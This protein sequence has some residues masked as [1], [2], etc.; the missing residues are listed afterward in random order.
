MRV[1]DTPFARFHA[2]AGPRHHPEILSGLELI[3]YILDGKR[4]KR[5]HPSPGF[6]VYKV[7]AQ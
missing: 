2:L 4:D 7:V 6:S 3:L 5:Y 1:I